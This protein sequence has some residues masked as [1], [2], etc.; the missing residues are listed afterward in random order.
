MIF[1]KIEKSKIK[2]IFFWFW[3]ILFFVIFRFFD[4]KFSVV[5]FS[6]KKCR[7][8]FRL[9]FFMIK[10]IVH[11]DFFLLHR[12]Y[13]LYP[14]I[15]FWAPCGGL[16]R[17]L[18]ASKA[19]NKLKNLDFSLKITIWLVATEEGRG[20]WIWSFDKFCVGESKVSELISKLRQYFDFWSFA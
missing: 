3:K 7:T 6:K 12:S 11:S 18:R 5:F 14:K 4:W 8:L 17:W 16:W 2:N 19:L 13:F 9:F 15:V 1:F 10:N 20:V